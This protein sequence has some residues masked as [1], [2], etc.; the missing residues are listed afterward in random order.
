MHNF[1]SQVSKIFGYVAVA[2][3]QCIWAIVAHY[4]QT[5]PQ[6]VSDWSP[7]DLQL[8]EL[9][10]CQFWLSNWLHWLQLLFGGKLVTHRLHCMCDRGIR[11]LHGLVPNPFC[12][13]PSLLSY[14]IS[15]EICTRFL[16]CCA[17]LWLYID[18]FSRIHQAYFTGT[19]AI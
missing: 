2:T 16:L 6:L 17:L 12:W 18:W 19:V 11:S 3:C 5:S 14:S 7:I 13:W 4:S 1:G 9:Q 15:Q 10:I 8:K